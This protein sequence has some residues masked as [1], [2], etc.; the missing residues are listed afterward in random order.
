MSNRTRLSERELPY[1]VAEELIRLPSVIFLEAVLALD[2]SLTPSVDVGKNS[3]L[4][5]QTGVSLPQSP[6]SICC[7]RRYVASMQRRRERHI[8]EILLRVA[9]SGPRRSS[10]Q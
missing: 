9:Q 5:G 2:D 4:S 8:V 7:R 6:R 3:M 1:Q 10:T